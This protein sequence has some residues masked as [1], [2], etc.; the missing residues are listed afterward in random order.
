MIA[1]A[2][3]SLLLGGVLVYAW[4]ESRRSPVVASLSLAAALAGLYFVWFPSHSTMVAEFVGV[5]RGVDLILYLWVCISL[6]VLL[7]LHL[8]LRTQHELITALARHIAL[9]NVRSRAADEVRDVASPSL[10]GAIAAHELRPEADAGHKSK[11][12]S[13]HSA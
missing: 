5:G 7:N 1:Q 12:M 11:Q 9:A 8:K 2:L 10:S 4:V 3:L 13:G 6:I